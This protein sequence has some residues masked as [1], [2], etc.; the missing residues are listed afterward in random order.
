MA[1]KKAPAKKMAAPKAPAKKM[2]APAKAAPKKTSKTADSS[3]LTPS[4]KKNLAASAKM[5]TDKTGSSGMG[6]NKGGV[7]ARA[8]D[9][10][11]K[12]YISNFRSGGGYSDKYSG[13]LM[14]AVVADQKNK[15]SEKQ[16]DKEALAAANQV[17]KKYGL[18]PGKKVNWPFQ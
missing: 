16:R 6:M 2:S 18:K 9:A 15:K 8:T 1:A 17:R 11:A 3:K 4:Q 10:A 12:A 14:E 7:E 13:L 5:R